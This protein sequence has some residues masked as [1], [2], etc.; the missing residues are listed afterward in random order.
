MS[1][2]KKR[3][4]SSISGFTLIEVL[5]ALAIIAV[6]LPALIL[7][8]VRTA[9]QAGYLKA[10][11]FAHWVAMNKVSELR[12]SDQ[13][14]AIGRQNGTQLMAEHEW[15]WNVEIKKTLY[16]DVRRVEVSVQPEEQTEGQPLIK[17]IAYLG[18][19]T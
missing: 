2:F 10:K 13:W 8:G 9:E 6:A 7:T 15:R 19:P 1:H 3:V 5:V 14:P 16:N 17:L 4:N 11:T 12:L 18:R